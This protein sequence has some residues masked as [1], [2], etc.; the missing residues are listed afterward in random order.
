MLR[1]LSSLDKTNISLA[2]F[3]SSSEGFSDD[4][5]DRSRFASI[6]S[7]VSKNKRRGT[8]FTGSFVKDTQTSVK[9]KKLSCS[10]CTQN[11]LFF[12]SNP[13]AE[14][15]ENLSP[16]SPKESRSKVFT[17]SKPRTVR[18]MAN[19]DSNSSVKKYLRSISFK[20]IVLN[21]YEQQNLKCKDLKRR[22]SFKII[23]KDQFIQRDPK[24]TL[25][26]FHVCFIGK[27]KHQSW[28][29]DIGC[30]RHMTR[31]KHMFKDLVMKEGGIVGFG[32][33]QRG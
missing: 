24:M 11:V 30:S 1:Q 9:I 21:K 16:S 17:K 4:D 31:E 6:S 25:L 32:G 18:F 28:Y 2:K 23:P 7:N 33:N 14:K 8:D 3:D 26:V 12:H 13:E 22:K 15:A 10:Y 20:P 27:Q 5:F 19:W 29:L